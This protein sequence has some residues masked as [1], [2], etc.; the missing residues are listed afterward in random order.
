MLSSMTGFV[1]KTISLPSDNEKPI[2]LT[3]NIK[4]LNSRFFEATCRLSHA[5]S[6]LETDLIKLAKNKLSRG[7]MYLTITISD[8]NTF[9]GD[10]VAS[11]STVKGYLDALEHIKDEFK[12]PGVIEIKDVLRIPN[13]FVAEELPV[14]EKIKNFV[15]KN[16]NNIVDEL[17]KIRDAE[18]KFLLVDLKKRTKKMLDE[19]TEIKKSFKA[20]FKEKEEGINTKIKGLSNLDPE[21]IKQQRMQLYQELD[22]A[23]L[24]EEIVRFNTHLKSFD[25]LLKK[26]KQEKGR[27][28]DFVL[29]ELGREANT[30]AAKTSDSSISAHAI[31]I[32]VE[33]EKCREQIQNIV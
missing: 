10:I 4:T 17:L 12:I 1:S 24:H 8:P 7:H 18:G 32:K 33:L 30:I 28:L 11:I 31:S 14:N 13:V 26:K 3:V 6:S 29:Q 15:I 27:Q 9:K 19:I 2:N 22:R 20:I 5:L 16:F 25:A 21:F 23:D